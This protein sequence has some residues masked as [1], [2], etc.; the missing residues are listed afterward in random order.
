MNDA[1]FFL[2]ILFVLYLGDCFYWLHRHAAVFEHSP[3][4]VN[5]PRLAGEYLGNYRRGLVYANPFPPLGSL[6]RCYPWPLSLAPDRVA[7]YISQALTDLGQPPQLLSIVDYR[8]IQSLSVRGKKLFINK[9]L[10]AQCPTE[11]SALDMMRL[12]KALEEFTVEQR[13][14]FIVDALNKTL[15]VTELKKRIADFQQ[16]GKIPRILAN[17]LWGYLF[18]FSPAVLWFSGSRWL[19]LLLAVGVLL[20]HIPIV[21]FFWMAHRRLYPEQGDER[22]NLFI[23][24]LLFPPAAVRVGDALSLDLLKDF[25]PLAAASVYCTPKQ[26]RRF[27]RKVL[28][29]LQYPLC[30]DFVTEEIKAVEQWQ[31]KQLLDAIEAF[32]KKNGT[33][34][35]DL[36]ETPVNRDSAARSHCPRCQTPYIIP[37]GTCADCHGVSL[38][39]Y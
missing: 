28:L 3:W 9:Q 31:R 19:L 17:V 27:A 25:H 10:F 15:D 26:F 7:S 18:I 29:D 38:K 5:N 39:S 11:G 8:H 16:C 22:M 14:G 33:T 34:K 37:T 36:L 2:L 32:L 13:E 24:M 35:E 20:L 1:Q 30:P 4:P 6:F 21:I 23:H 12:V